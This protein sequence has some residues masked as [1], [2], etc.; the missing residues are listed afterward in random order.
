MSDPVATV[1]SMLWTEDAPTHCPYGHELGPDRVL[2]GWDAGRSGSLDH[3]HRVHICRQ[4][5]T[6]MSWTP[7]SRLE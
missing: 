7:I 6:I 1:R 2:V 5:G 3:G 4:C